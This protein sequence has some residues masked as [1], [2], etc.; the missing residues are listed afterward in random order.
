MTAHKT[1]IP[2]PYQPPR[3]LGAKLRRRFV[4]HVSRQRVPMRLKRPVVSFTFDDVPSSVMETALP[5]LEL[6]GWRSTLYVATGLMGTIN[7]HG[8]MMTA[9]EICRV[10]R[11]GHEIGGHGHDHMN[12]AVAELDDVVRDVNTSHGIFDAMGV[13]IPRSFAW[14]YGEVGAPVKAMLA[15]RYETLR[16]T[17][18]ITHTRHADFNQLAGMR[19]FSGDYLDNVHA[20]L[21]RLETRPGWL[22]LFGHD[23]RQNASEW[24]C[25]PAEFQAVVDH[26]LDIG[27]DVRTV[28]DMA[29][30]MSR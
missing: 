14:P 10:A 15:E 13:D 18:Q 1:D 30:E 8:R 11:D 5:M 3:G 22:I 29:Q 27:A 12:Y 16:G 4:P 24:G 9:N 26:V 21:D 25:T 6:E 20:A 28:G 23:V 7:H 19:L 17:R 2:S